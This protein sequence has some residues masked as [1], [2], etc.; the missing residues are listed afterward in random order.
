MLQG[1]TRSRFVP[2]QIRVDIPK[3]DQKLDMNFLNLAALG[4]TPPMTPKT[5]Q[6]GLAKQTSWGGNGKYFGLQ[7]QYAPFNDLKMQIHHPYRHR[8][9][10]HRIQ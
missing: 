8:Y 6:G 3:N 4:P 1:K 10:C 7:R 2:G 5:P 9:V